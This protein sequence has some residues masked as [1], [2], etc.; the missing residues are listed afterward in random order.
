MG[1]RPTIWHGSKFAKITLA[2][3]RKLGHVN[4]KIKP[5][6]DDGPKYSDWEANDRII[7]SWLL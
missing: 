5:R 3:E 7:I 2:G 4:G 6:L 1:P